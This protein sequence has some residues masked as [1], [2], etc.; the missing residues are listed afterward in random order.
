[1]ATGACG[2]ARLA[3]LGVVVWRRRAA[4]AVLVNPALGPLIVPPTSSDATLNNSALQCATPPLG[5]CFFDTGDDDGWLQHVLPMWSG[6]SGASGSSSLTLPFT[7]NLSAVRMLGGLADHDA[8]AGTFKS[9][10]QWDLASCTQAGT[11]R[12]GLCS[13]TGPGWTAR[14]T[15]SSRPASPRARWSSTTSRK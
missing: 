7:R 3:D 5:R 14:S 15:P 13:T 8:A 2:G 4:R 10:P 1:M 11:R 6:G 12:P 9:L